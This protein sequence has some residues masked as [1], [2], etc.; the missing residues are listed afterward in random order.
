[1]AA[2]LTSAASGSVGARRGRRGLA[3]GLAGAGT[4]SRRGGHRSWPGVRGSPPRRLIEKIVARGGRRDR[5]KFASGGRGLVGIT[6][7]QRVGDFLG[8]AGLD[9]VA[10]VVDVIIILWVAV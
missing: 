9:Q 2:V 6:R 7:N 5:R 3:D 10:L 4:R 1:M 8:P